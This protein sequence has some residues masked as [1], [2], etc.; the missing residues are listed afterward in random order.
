MMQQPRSRGRL[1]LRSMAAWSF[2]IGLAWLLLGQQLDGQPVVHLDL[3]AGLPGASSVHRQPAA[4]RPPSAR[5]GPAGARPA[6][7]DLN[8]ILNAALNGDLTA[9]AALNGNLNRNLNADLTGGGARS[10]VRARPAGQALRVRRRRLRRLRLLRPDLVGL[11]ARGAVV[12][13]DER[14][15]AVVLAPPARPGRAG[16]AASPQGDLLL[17]A[18]DP[19]DPASIRHVA[20]A[21][22][23]RRMVEAPKPGIPVRVVPVRWPGLFAAARP[24]A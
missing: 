13:A 24:V 11:A 21:V 5:P 1:R 15:R 20:M 8:A 9:A 6:S 12:A 22:G 17:D 7:A 16:R 14:R 3:T 4:A 10:R 19:H 2:G 23:D 18:N